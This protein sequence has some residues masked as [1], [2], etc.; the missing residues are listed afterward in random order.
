M[1]S[2]LLLLF[3][4]VGFWGFGQTTE[5]TCDASTPSFT[6]DLTGNPDSLWVSPQ[7]RRDGICCD[8]DRDEKPP[9]RCVEFFFTLD[10][11]AIGIIF[12]IQ[13]GAEPGGSMFYQ[14]NCQGRYKV[15]DE[16]CL[17]G[18]GPYRLTFCKP[19][20]NPNTYGLKSIGPPK[21][22]PPVTVSD[23]CGADLFAWGYDLS[24]VTWTS[25]PD[26]PFYNSLLSCRFQCDSVHASYGVGAPDSVLYQVSGFPPGSC[27]PT[28]VV[29]QTWVYFV[30]D[31]KVDILPKDAAIC[32]GANT[33]DLTAFPTGGK[34]PYKY[35]WSTG[36]TSKTISVGLGKYWVEVFDETSCPT[37]NDTVEVT[38]FNFPILADAGKD[39]T[40]CGANPSIQLNGKIQEA[41]GGKWSGGNG[42]FLPNDSTL[43]TT[44]TATTDEVLAGQITL[45]LST[46]GNRSCPGNIDDVI[47]GFTP[48]PK[49]NAGNDAIICANNTSI[50][51][52]GTVNNALKGKWFGGNG[53]F[54]PNDSTLNVLYIPSDDEINGKNFQLFLQTLGNG[55][56]D[57]SIDT[58]DIS[59]TPA[60]TLTVSN[61]EVCE[62]NATINLSA[63]ITIA[64]GITWTNGTGSFSPNNTSLTTTYKLSAQEI[65]AKQA[66]LIVTTTGNGTCLPVS[67]PVII[68]VLAAPIVDAGPNQTI[69]VNN[70][71]IQLDGNIT[72]A[73]GGSWSGGNGTFANTSDLKTT[74]QPSTSEITNGLIVLTLTSTG[75]GTCFPV[76]D[77]VVINILPAPIVDAGLPQT[78][79]ANNATINLVGTVKNA[80]GIQWST[81]GTGTFSPSN[82]N[83]S[84]TYNPSPVDTSL[85]KIKIFITSTNNGLCSAVI[86]SMELDITPAPIVDAG[87]PQTVCENN[88]SI[89]LTGNVSSPFEGIW[90]G[91]NGSFS[92]NKNDLNATYILTN[93]E[94]QNKSIT[95]TLTSSNNGNCLPVSDQVVF[96][97]LGKPIVDL[98]NDLSICADQN[99]I[100]IQAN[101]TNATK[102]VWSGGKGGTF[103]DN[104]SLTTNYNFTQNEIKDSLITLFFKTAESSPCLEE[105][106]QLLIRF[107]PIVEIEAGPPQLLCKGTDKIFLNGQVKIAQGVVWSSNGTGTF[108]PNATDLNAVYTP[109]DDDFTNNNLILTLTSTN[110]GSCNV[111]SDNVQMTFVDGPSINTGDDVTTCT[112]DFPIQLNAIGSAGKWIGNGGTFTTSETFANAQY[113]PSDTEINAGKTSL[114][115]ITNPT[116]LCPSVQDVIE[117]SFLDGPTINGGID[118]I[119]CSNQ[120]TINFNASIQ[121]ASGVTWTSSGNGTLSPSATGLTYTLASTEK[122]VNDTLVIRFTAST[123]NNPLCPIEDDIIEVK[124]T[125]TP[126]IDAG[127]GQTVCRNTDKISLNGTVQNASGVTWTSSG[128]GTFEKNNTL[129]DNAYLITSQDTSTKSITLTLTSTDNGVCPAVSDQRIIN[130]ESVPIVRAGNDISLCEDV[131][132]IPLSANVS[133]ANGVTWKT[134]NGKGIFSPNPNL[135]NTSYIR[136]VQDTLLD[137]IVLYVE[138]TGNGVCSPIYD[139]LKLSFTPKVVVQP[140]VD[141]TVCGDT[142]FI[143]LTPN[144]INATGGTWTTS[145]NGTFKNVNILQNFYFPSED[146]I[147]KGSVFITLTSTGNGSC[148]ANSNDLKITFTPIPTIDAGTDIIIC[149]DAENLS[150]SGISQIATGGKWTSNGTGTFTNPSNLTTDYLVKANDT[151]LSTLEFYLTS[152][153]NGLC[154]AVVDTLS[155]D[156]TPKP[157]I[158]AGND[159]LACYSD[160][161]I[162]LKGNVSI[163]TG[164]QWLSSGNGVFTPSQNLL[165][166]QYNFTSID[167]TKDSIQFILSSTGNGT[168]KSIN[169]TTYVRFTNPPKIDL[170]DGLVCQNIGGGTSLNAKVQDATSWKWTSAGT[171]KFFPSDTLLD[172]EYIPSATDMS[173][174]SV[175]LTFTATSCS[176]TSKQILF[177][178]TPAPIVTA[179]GENE[180][181]QN[182]PTQLNASFKNAG[183]ISWKSLGGGSFSPSN[184]TLNA[185][186]IVS[187]A[188]IINEKATIIIETTNNG[189]CLPSYD[190]LTIPVLPK[191]IVNAG[192]AQFICADQ[193]TLDISGVLTGVTKATW[194][195]LGTGSFT[196]SKA[197]NT[198]YNISNSDKKVGKVTLLLTS[199]KEKCYQAVTGK[200]DISIRQAPTIDAGKDIIACKDAPAVIFS[201]SVNNATGVLWTS[202]G[203]G[204]FESPNNTKTRY[205]FSEADKQAGKVTLTLSSVG[206]EMCNSVSDDVI[207]NL[208]GVP[209]VNLGE[210]LFYCNEKPLIPV[211]G[212][213]KTLFTNDWEWSSSGNGYFKN[214]NTSLEDIYHTTAGDT[215]TDS[216][217][218]FLTVNINSGCVNYDFFDVYFF[219][220][221]KLKLYDEPACIGDTIILNAQPI[222]VDKIGTYKWF[223][224]DTLIQEGTEPELMVLKNGTYST[225]FELG[226]CG[227]NGKTDIEFFDKPIIIN[228]EVEEICSEN[229][230]SLTLDAG[231]GFSY[232][233]F[234]FYEPDVDL[235]QRYLTVRDVGTFY[236]KITSQYGCYDIDSI[237]VVDA[238]PPRVFVPTIFSPNGDGKNDIM[239]I[240][241]AYY[242]NYNLTIFNRWGEIIFYTEDRYE[243]WDG[244]YRGETMPIG[245]YNWMINYEGQTAK[246]RGPYTQKGTITIVK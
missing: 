70:S 242:K 33:A 165:T 53:Q 189:N 136:A 183:G 151:L 127:N 197:L 79:C 35:V 121:N 224:N 123:I 179:T 77:Q 104:T 194:T 204:T 15:G 243:F 18:P 221:P 240:N 11:E 74:Y 45:T 214:N 226:T 124:L 97:I 153:G 105:D 227:A 84:S 52:N 58:I 24:T 26:D 115:F 246:Y 146:D 230:T 144:I 178:I 218:I 30:N 112:N 173:T 157:V 9:F 167:K 57:P 235:T 4:F 209:D 141:V 211:K 68:D 113:V 212:D 196:D 20:N 203:T 37:T 233:W 176:T 130:F 133:N 86:D 90:S 103:D 108:S 217:R 149:E 6:F 161:S 186:Y 187:T 236:V 168:C 145:G 100:Q 180:L 140:G 245:V 156:F 109:S 131:E 122:N 111:Y 175:T 64:N 193:N 92:L 69:C 210:N 241:G 82:S 116:D 55:T 41:L 148:N 10:K 150:L 12:D 160:N 44:Y 222:N 191:P 36:D 208:M 72:N 232:E 119:I 169:D 199:D 228:N 190:T 101:L 62:N 219:D 56:C 195:S 164:G 174:G 32:F 49:A 128:N 238:C 134:E 25:V 155:V 132:N 110:N 5:P 239:T 21:V 114:T 172:P 163:A 7:V 34:P 61:A 59:V 27:S 95:L 102:G 43:N 215:L 182:T 2:Q 89:Q 126:S 31:K 39:T 40:V 184:T 73:S 65:Q 154:K 81:N 137:P 60:P 94:I 28:P 152:T 207:L 13:S 159:L 162:S 147:Q 229:F 85:K 14:I 63:S 106:D 8:I 51:L 42:T 120:N 244:K 143:E 66:S 225:D 117:I 29:K 185:T 135:L 129:I 181:C 1:K 206:Q 234:N 71:E 78:V 91:G 80:G 67:Y 202:A 87:L 139:T 50:Q 48:V 170:G 205:V 213:V 177:K 107:T 192:T 83:I 188:D 201:G 47:I 237:Q 46:T 76:A 88:A 171:G 23:G 93:P 3:I 22:S 223:K 96:T 38:A 98:G 16:L 118:K 220:G 54:L 216:I 142:A 19:G 158:N 17:D 200:V 75:N 231:P 99:Q 138:S 166:T 125:P 198:T